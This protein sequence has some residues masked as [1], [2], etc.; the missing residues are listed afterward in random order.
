MYTNQ[1]VAKY[2]ESK[3]LAWAPTSIKS[4][5][6]RL[7]SGIEVVNRLGS[8]ATA[9]QV[10]E[11][12]V[13]DGHKPYSIKTM[14]IR[15]A[16]FEEFVSGNSNNHFRQFLTINARLFKSVYQPKRLEITYL[17]AHK[18]ISTIPNT[19]IREICQL[20]LRSGLRVHEALSYDGTGSVV[21][22]GNKRRIVYHMESSGATAKAGRDEHP[23]LTYKQIYMALKSVNLTPHV[24]RKLAATTLVNAG[25]KEA[26]LMRVMGWSS[27]ATAAIYVQ[28]AN[29][30]ELAKRVQEALK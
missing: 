22:K 4:E 21:G 5:W 13:S 2:I 8:Q 26:D 10:Y 7:R 23:T 6:A 20:M 12:L 29:D 11:Q 30:V 9:A 18:R 19:D 28:P 16:E 14:F 27:M 25:F 24:L 1:N 17:E 15:L 3:K